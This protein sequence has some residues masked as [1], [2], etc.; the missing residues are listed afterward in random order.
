MAASR[1]P[2][3]R[4]AGSPLAPDR[5]SRS[6]RA[7]GPCRDAVRAVDVPPRATG[8]SVW[9]EPKR[10]DGRP[11]IAEPARNGSAVSRKCRPEQRSMLCHSSLVRAALCQHDPLGDDHR[12]PA[13]VTRDH[14]REPSTTIGNHEKATRVDQLALDLNEQERATAGVPGDEVDHAALAEVVE[15]CLWPDLPAGGD[16]HRG[17]PLFH[18]GVAAGDD[19]L[20]ATASPARLDLQSDFEHG[21]DFAERAE[22]DAVKVTAFDRRIQSTRHPRLLRDIELPPPQPESDPSK[23]PADTHVIHRC[24][25]VGPGAYPPVIEKRRVTRRRRRARRTGRSHGCRRRRRHG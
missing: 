14:A 1:R 11:G 19:A 21:R 24:R 2:R 16:Q 13:A 23:E 17:N 4:L 20:D 7:R 5:P 15:R 22:R 3:K 18:R 25:I 9:Q 8:S 6:R 10:V 12:P